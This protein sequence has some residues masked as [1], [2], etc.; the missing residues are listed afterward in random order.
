MSGG[1]KKN[2][3]YYKFCLYGFF[4]NL[5][6]FEAFLL[7][8]FLDKGLTYL[9]IGLL[10]TI[11]EVVK[12]A[13][14]IPSGIIADAFGRRKVLISSFFFY[15]ISFL[16]FSF[17]GSFILFAFSM[18]FFSFGDAFRTGVHKAMIFNYLKVNNWADQ[19]VDYYG[20]TRSW[21]QAGS[22]ISAAIAALIVFVTGAYNTI[23][24]LAIIPY[25]IDAVLIWSYPKF[26]DGDKT[27]LDKNRL[28]SAFREVFS[29][30]K[31][32][33]KKPALL[34][35]LIS[36][37]LY[38]GYYKSVKD[39]VQPI[40][41]TLAI[42]TPFFAYLNN[43]KKTA[44]II[45]IFY[46]IAY[47]LTSISSK[48]AQGF[49]KLFSNASKA[50]KISILIGFM[51]GVIIGLAFIEQ[52]YFASVIGFVIILMVENIRKPIGISMVADNTDD[53]AMAT[54]LSVES[55]TKSL[56]AAVIAP[57][58]GFIADYYSPGISILIV[59][60]ILILISL[61]FRPKNKNTQP[62]FN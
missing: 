39:Y 56:F 22:A 36:L 4:K 25:L 28:I 43:E 6:F 11:R 23:F 58:L 16:G 1:F 20:H 2:L 26:L 38:T 48:N 49:N 54:I 18:S 34:K 7:L 62:Q 45:G 33:I 61:F 31:L 57:V 12:A 59:S 27:K 41:K 40:I 15:I 50:M 37:S 19:K 60:A 9:E 51:S 21:S 8:F 17:S 55:Q 24:L 14:E 5:R 10:Y 29:G 46:F 32:S 42:S 35:P 44:V 53:K 47:I 13:M 3:Q 52:Y 30:L